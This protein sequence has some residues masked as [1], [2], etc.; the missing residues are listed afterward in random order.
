[1]QLTQATR[2]RLGIRGIYIGRIMDCSHNT[3]RWAY[4]E[5]GTVLVQ[6]FIMGSAR[7]MPAREPD[8]IFLDVALAGA[9]LTR[10][11]DLRTITR[12][13]R[14]RSEANRR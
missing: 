4:D 14:P 13:L 8:K 2:R 10:T 12:C 7:H 6:R 3:I 9:D 1:M 5:E 11:E